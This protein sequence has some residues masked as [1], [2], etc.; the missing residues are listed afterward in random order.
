MARTSVSAALGDPQARM[1]RL[2]RL[3]RPSGRSSLEFAGLGALLL[4][5]VAATAWVSRIPLILTH[6]ESVY[7]VLARHWLSGTPATGVANH[8]APLLPALGVPVLALDGG[9]MG[10]R[11]VGIVSGV[12]ALLAVWW[13]ARRLRG[14]VAGLLA[15]AVFAFST[16]VFDASTLFLTDLPAAGLLLLMVAVL[17]WQ[18]AERPAPNRALLLVAPLAWGAYELRFGSALVVV[19]LFGTTWL[20]F[21]RAVQAHL[22]LVLAMVILLVVLLVPHLVNSTLDMGTPISRLLYTS[23]IAG[24][25]YLGEGLV[26]YVR[27]FP[28]ALAGPLTAALMTVGLVGAV[29]VWSTGTTGPGLV[30]GA[31]QQ[32]RALAFLLLPALAHVVLI[33]IASHGEP[34]FVFFAIGLLCVAGAVIVTDVLATLAGRSEQLVWAALAAAVLILATHTALLAR[35]DSRARDAL[36]REYTVLEE[37]AQFIRDS[38]GDGCSVLTSYSPQMTWMTACASYHFGSPPISGRERYLSGDAWMALYEEGKRQPEGEVLEHYLRFAEEVEAW[39]PPR[40]GRFGSGAVY[41]LDVPGQAAPAA[42]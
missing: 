5:F 24:R 8:R 35:H 7:A 39:D 1:T 17:W 20:L 2:A 3:L 6:D 18:F 13:L 9:E 10:L 28:R 40:V 25:A 19:L 4:A 12:G 37:S 14:P 21:R 23:E 33:G 38:S 30:G 36:A 32:Q 29:V 15:A 41:R 42:Q 22:R 34:R 16:S 26:D 27:W 31:S 11:A